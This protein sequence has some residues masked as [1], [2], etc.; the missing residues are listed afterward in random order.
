[1]N[2]ELK[3]ALL[4]KTTIDNCCEA[5]INGV[6]YNLV[7]LEEIEKATVAGEVITKMRAKWIGNDGAVVDVE[8][9]FCL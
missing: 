9:V 1:M 6:K 2:T 7:G 4:K 8:W 3:S 5:E